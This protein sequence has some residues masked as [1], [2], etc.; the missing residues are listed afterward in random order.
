METGDLV[1]LGLVGGG[2]YLAW[3]FWQNYKTAGVP[4]TPVADATSSMN[5]SA[6]K[7]TVFGPNVLLN[8]LFPSVLPPRLPPVV[9][10][11]TSPDVFAAVQRVAGAKIRTQVFQ[12]A[13]SVTPTSPSPNAFLV[14]PGI[15]LPAPL[16]TQ[17]SGSE[18]LPGLPGGIVFNRN[19]LN[20]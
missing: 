17:P 3:R 8:K 9:P 4:G 1:T 19:L 18:V 14:V 7:S 2:A 13:A 20:P 15:G 12:A 5:A 6:A 11:E 16:P 10:P